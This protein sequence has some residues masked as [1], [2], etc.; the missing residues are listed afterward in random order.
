MATKTFSARRSKL[1]DH[2]DILGVKSDKEVSRIAGVSIEN[3]RTYRLRRGIPAG[4]RGE[5]VEA[6]QAKEA[7]RSRR[8]KP[9]RRGRRRRGMR[10]RASRLEPFAH[11]LGDVP[12]RELAQRA[13]VTP[14]NV[15]S[16]R[17][18]RGIPAR[19][20]GEGA[21]AGQETEGSAPSPRSAGRSS[22]AGGGFAFRVTTNVDGTT[23]DYV[24][25]GPDMVA[26]AAEAQRRLSQRHP[27]A[28]LK[29]IV[30]VGESL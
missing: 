12:D 25:F 28:V 3:V 10:P 19:W 16:Y 14:E 13:G 26:A 18:R 27:G 29:E 15:R 1:D 6:L 17:K 24:V 2:A 21:S 4:W 8:R 11:M 22:S 20:R 7:F 23:K 30:M 9:V 5:T